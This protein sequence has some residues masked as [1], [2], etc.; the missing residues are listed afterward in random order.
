MLLA[1]ALAACSHWPFATVR[2]QPL[3]FVL[4]THGLPQDGMWKS[5]PLLADLDEDGSLDLIALPRLG[6]GAQVWLGDGKGGWREASAGL[7]LAASCGGGVAAADLNRDG[8]L[9][10]VV[11]DH[12]AG[13]FV[14][15]GDGH[16][17]WRAVT[18]GLN[19]AAAQQAPASADGDNPFTG[20]EDVAVADVNHDGFPDLVVAARQEGGITVYFGDGSGRKWTE[21]H[22]DGLPK[23]GW[24]N[25]LLV[26]DIDGDGHP[27]L[28]ASDV[29]GPRVW[30]GDGRGHWQASS[31]GLPHPNAGGFYRQIAVGDVNGD[32]R[33]DLAF[34]NMRNGVELY[35]QTEA[36]T[37]QAALPPMPVMTGGAMSVALADLDRD[38]H[39]DLVV[40][41]RMSL[42]SHYGLFVLHGDGK[43]GWSRL[44]NTDLPADGLTFVWGIT[45]AD[46]NR[47]GLPD[48]AVSTGTAPLERDPQEPA[49]RLQVWLN[50]YRR[51]SPGAR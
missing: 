47:D 44:Q 13:V 8:H 11:A 30:R 45:L 25:K 27:D 29:D 50:H 22:G 20:A 24:A 12:C 23:S 5:T 3:K 6:H 35:L 39:L 36:G 21:A 26:T 18:Q 46:V 1:V 4:A 34:A 2:S 19:P 14:Y 15:L 31:Q 7:D 37:W 48:L 41:G 51:P 32:G 17:H 43:G 28:V 33:L 49:P 38:G 9:D 16:G 42:K 10:L 40:G